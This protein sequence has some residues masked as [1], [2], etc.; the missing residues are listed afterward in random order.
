MNYSIQAFNER[1]KSASE[2]DKT[3]STLFQATLEAG[4]RTSIADLLRTGGPS[5]WHFEQ[6]QAFAQTL[7]EKGDVL[8]Y[9]S[10]KKG[11]TAALMARFC[12]VVAIMAFMPGGVTLF[13]LHFE[14]SI[15]EE[16]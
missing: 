7:G 16:A 1:M 13:G 5:E 2:S 12:E 9:G 14:A 3:K 6:A 4:A 11:E 15:P 8:L 10:K